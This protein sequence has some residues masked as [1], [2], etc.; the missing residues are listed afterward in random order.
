[1]TEYQ[2]QMVIQLL[3]GCGYYVF[4]DGELYELYNRVEFLPKEPA[5][6]VNY[7]KWSYYVFKFDILGSCCLNLSLVTLKS[8]RMH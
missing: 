4:M 7:R 8:A 2:V 1:M 5:F 6:I 3:L